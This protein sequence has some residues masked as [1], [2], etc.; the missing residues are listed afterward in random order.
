M[1]NL[2]VYITVSCYS[3]IIC[4]IMGGVIEFLGVVISL[5]ASYIIRI[6]RLLLLD[7]QNIKR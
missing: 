5:E 4:R 2:Y 7:A 6:Q 3:V 1:Y